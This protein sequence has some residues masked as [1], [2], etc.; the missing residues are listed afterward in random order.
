M[1]GVA[2]CAVFDVPG[3]EHGVVLLAAVQVNDGDLT[4]EQVQ[5]WL[6]QRIAE[7]EVP[8]RVV[9][10]AALPRDEAGHVASHRLRAAYWKAPE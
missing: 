2:D 1:P 6:R 5:G 4:A 9:F 8:R 7:P 3:D 10:Y